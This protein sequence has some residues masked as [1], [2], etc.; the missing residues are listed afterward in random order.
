[1]SIRKFIRDI[2]QETYV[3]SV[4]RYTAVV[5]E[6]PAE[7]QKIENL[8]REY[9]PETGWTK[10]RNY[11]MT[12]SLGPIPDSLRNRGDLNKEVE[13]TISTIG[14]SAR[15]IALGTF[16]YYSKNEVP[17]I[18]LAFNKRGGEPADSKYISEWQ[19]IQN[20]K[21]KGVI[22][23]VGHGDKVLKERDVMNIVATPDRI[24]HA[25]GGSKFPQ[26]EDFDQFGNMIQ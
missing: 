6:E 24:A 26:P 3:P 7:I 23:E 19:P 18:T 11:H 13:L 17:H 25:G 1:M 21:V 12:I 10:A 9:V 14:I 15:A 16:G 5:I 20:I 4:V 22:R 2:I 8:Y